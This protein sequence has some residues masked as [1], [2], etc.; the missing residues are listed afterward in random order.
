MP[1]GYRVL[2]VRG[3][4]ELR[5]GD[6]PAELLAGAVELQD[7]DVVVVT[8]KAVSK[9]EGRLVPVPPGPHEPDAV[10]DP[11]PLSPPP[12][13]KATTIAAKAMPRMLPSPRSARLRS[14]VWWEARCE[15]LDERRR[16]FRRRPGGSVG[17]VGSVGSAGVVGGVGSACRVG[18][19]GV[20]GSAGSVGVVGAAG[21]VGSVIVC[22]APVTPRRAPGGARR[23]RCGTPSGGASAWVQ[24]KPAGHDP[25][26]GEDRQDR[27]D[28][29]DRQGARWCAA[30][31]G[32]CPREAAGGDAQDG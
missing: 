2:P 20:R 30:G 31:Q 29:A 18:S 32:G 28:R 27:E 3:L 13:T 21:S 24:D 19:V 16:R 7:G 15:E 8:S 17:S 23:A 5:P 22:L 4:P 25:G 10:N 11:R 9:I 6:D 26:T 12:S 1:D 14:E